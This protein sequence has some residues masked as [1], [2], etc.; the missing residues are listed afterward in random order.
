M[1]TVLIVLWST[2]EGTANVGTAAY[3]VHMYV[4][5]IVL[6]S[7]EE[8]TASV[9]ITGIMCSHMIRAIAPVMWLSFL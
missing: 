7:T 9:G 5:L 4:V 8:R 3:A 2:E 1:Y 6:G